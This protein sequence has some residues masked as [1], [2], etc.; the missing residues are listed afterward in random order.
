MSTF[1]QTQ[2]DLF[3]HYYYYYFFLHNTLGLGLVELVQ[4][5]TSYFVMININTFISPYSNAMLTNIS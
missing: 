4:L 5:S 3:G 2:E 1:I